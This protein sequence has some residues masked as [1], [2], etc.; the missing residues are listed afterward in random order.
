MQELIQTDN[1]EISMQP[2]KKKLAAITIPTVTD[3]NKA[4]PDLTSLSELNNT[5]V[6]FNGK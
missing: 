6:N 4:I 3:S 5:D 1:K 2:D